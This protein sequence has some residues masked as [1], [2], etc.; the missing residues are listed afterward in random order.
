MSK[1]LLLRRAN[2]ED[3]RRILEIYSPYCLNTVISF[4]E[5]APSLEEMTSRIETVGSFY[6][7]LVAIKDDILVGYAYAGPHRKREAYQW[8]TET[9]IY[10]DENHRGKGIGQK[11]YEELFDIL[12]RQGF[13]N[14]YAGITMPNK[15]SVAFHR[16]QGFNQIG[17]YEKIGFKM[18]EWLDVSWWHRTI[19]PYPIEKPNPPISVE[20]C[21]LQNT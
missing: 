18:G 9:S 14:G 21:F 1:D 2:H 4:E 5:N 20:E 15:A 8:S 11:L 17:V 6:P 3:A 16:S 12:A 19:A 10:M 13:I 7:W